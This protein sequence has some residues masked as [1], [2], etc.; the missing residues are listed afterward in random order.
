[1][2]LDNIIKNTTKR[3]WISAATF[4]DEQSTGDKSSNL[5]HQDTF[6]MA[7]IFFFE[8][9]DGER[10]IPHRPTTSRQLS[11]ICLQSNQLHSY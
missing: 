11:S 5:V 6:I 1:M 3:W 2:I 9:F 4:N 7:V 8:S 10:T